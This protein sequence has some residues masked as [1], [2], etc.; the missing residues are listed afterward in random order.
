MSFSQLAAEALQHAEG[1]EDID[2]KVEQAL[3]CPCLGEHGVKVAVLPADPVLTAA[4]DG[5]LQLCC[6]MSACSM[7]HIPRSHSLQPS[8]VQTVIS[9]SQWLV[10]ITNLTSPEFLLL[11]PAGDLKEGPCGPT[12][13]HAFTC[14]MKSEHEDKGM[15]CIDQFKSFQVRCCGDSRHL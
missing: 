1:E 14:F 11:L 3:A 9:L 7:W 15:D 2:K 10:R 6:H 5:G 13:V 4:G 8:P 12:F